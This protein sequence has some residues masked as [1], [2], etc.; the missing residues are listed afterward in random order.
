MR[1]IILTAGYGTRMGNLTKYVP[2]SLIPIANKPILQH[3][4]ENLQQCGIRDFI[5]A[6]GHLKNQITSFLTK[7]QEKDLNFK[8]KFAKDF[9]KGPLYS[10]SACLS[11]IGDEDFILVPADLLIDPKALADL[12]R[13][14]ENGHLTLAFNN[15][16]S[17]AHRSIIYLSSDDQAPQVLGLTLKAREGSAITKSLVP[18]LISRVDFRSYVNK[19]LEL[20]QTKVIDAMQLFLEEKNQVAAYMIQD[21]FWFDLDTIRDALAANAFFLEQGLHRESSPINL[22]LLKSQDITVKKPVIIGDDCEINANCIIGPNVS[23]GDHSIIRQHVT[24]QNAI[25]F[26]SSKVPAASE[27]RNA[28]FFKTIHQTIS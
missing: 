12:L 16:R 21:G 10:F 5:F 23:I 19:S 25:V 18:L 22:N 27:V 28:I 15:M 24:L 8:I 26:P 7:M 9:K 11:E 20:N 2:K 4:I 6:V 1:A 3:L 14:S 17:E 13:K